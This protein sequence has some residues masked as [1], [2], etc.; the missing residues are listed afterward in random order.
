MVL[1]HGCQNVCDASDTPRTCGV[2]VS[3]LEWPPHLQC[4]ARSL[5]TGD[6]HLSCSPTDRPDAF[7]REQPRAASPGAGVDKAQGEDISVCHSF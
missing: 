4:T 3:E 7:C 1:V 2:D 6:R 5:P